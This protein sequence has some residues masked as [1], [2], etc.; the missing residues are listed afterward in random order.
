M[1]LATASAGAAPAKPD[2]KKNDAPANDDPPAPPPEA[3]KEDA[4]K[5]APPPLPDPRSYRQDPRPIPAPA[6]RAPY[7]TVEVGPD[8]GIIQRPANG[9]GVHADPGY[10]LGGHARIKALPWLDARLSGR[11]EWAPFSYDDGALGLPHGTRVD[12][13]TGNRVYLS[14]SAEPTFSPLP[15]LDLW[16]GVGIAWGRTLLPTLQSSGS[17]AVT[18]PGRAA[19]FVEVPFSAGV[20]YELVPHWLVVNL[21]CSVGVPFARSGGLLESYRTP[22]KDGTLV[23]VAGYPEI[24]VSVL[25]LAGVGLLL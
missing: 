16:A 22:G 10:V 3:P 17:E 5:D 9:N 11:V 7:W 19:V 1:L 20:R 23:T 14:A 24:G 2:A 6:P 21:S 12:V 18:V 8:T 13:G 15:R 4:P 25:G